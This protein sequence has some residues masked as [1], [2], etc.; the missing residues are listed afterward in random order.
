[1]SLP[2]KKVVDFYYEFKNYNDSNGKLIYPVDIP[3]T[4]STDELAHRIVAKRMDPIMKF[5]RADKGLKV[6]LEHFVRVENQKFYDERDEL[7]LEQ[8]ATGHVDVD[9][10]ALDLE[11]LYKD[12]ILEYADRVG[13]SDDEIFAQSYHQLV[14]SSVLSE[15]LTKERDY[16]KTITNLTAQMTQQITT[17]NMLHQEEI[18]AKVRKLMYIY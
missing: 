14:H 7:L 13:P 18:E 8:L 2:G 3:Y 17:M 4:S 5:L 9:S 15:I 16:A 6:A 10:L 12:E 1:M 11:K